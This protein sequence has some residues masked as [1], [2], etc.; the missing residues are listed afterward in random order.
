[1]KRIV[2]G[3]LLFLLVFTSFLGCQSRKTAEGIGEITFEIYDESGEMISTKTVDYYEGDTLLGLLMKE[4]TVYCGDASGNPD[5]TCSFTG[6]YG[7]Y[8]MGVDTVEAFDAGE[9]IAFYI[10]GDYAMTGIDA[11]DI[12]DGNTY[13]FKYETYSIG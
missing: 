11:T 10:N 8:L 7:V 13:Q 1:M 9:Y 6:T 4:Y 12:V 5:D 2:L 3:I